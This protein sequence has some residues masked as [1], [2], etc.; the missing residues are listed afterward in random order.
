MSV[1]ESS[2]SEMKALPAAPEA[3]DTGSGHNAA[4]GRSGWSFHSIALRMLR[5][6]GAALNVV[7]PSDDRAARR[8]P[9]RYSTSSSASAGGHAELECQVPSPSW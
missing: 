9:A 1:L 3:A 4:H 6:F 5:G 7:S 2:G 8:S